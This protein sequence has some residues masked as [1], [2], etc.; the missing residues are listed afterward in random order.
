MPLIVAEA[1][2]PVPDPVITSLRTGE[3]AP[4][5]Q[6]ARG[7]ARRLAPDEATEA[8]PKW[9]RPEQA[10]SFQRTLHAVRRYGGA[11]LADPVGS[12]KTYVA[13]AVAA[14]L[15]PNRPIACLVPATLAGQWRSVATACGIHAVVSSHQA[16]SRGRLPAPT[17]GPVLIDEAHHFRNPSTRRYRHVAPWLIGRPVLL[18]TATPVVNRVED[19]LHQLLLGI[20][21]DALSLEGISSL[22]GLL[23]KGHGSPG[24]GSVVIEGAGADGSRPSRRGTVSESSRIEC[25]AADRALEAID[26][27]GLSSHSA[28]ARLVRSVLR[29]AAASSPAALTAALRRYRGLLLHARDAAAAGR[30][31]DRAAIRRFAGPVEDQLVWWELMPS[32]EDHGDLRLDDLHDIGEVLQTITA[33][34]A[35]PDG[36]L[37]RVRRLLDDGR[38]TLVFSSHRETVRYLR[39]RLGPPPVA[40]CTGTR[41]GLG[42]CPMPRS[43][44]LGWFRE[45]PGFGAR[46]SVR[47]LLVTDVAAEG[48]D[49]QRAGRVVH[50]DLPWTPMRI[51]Q[52]EG[53]A[54]RLGSRHREVEVVTFKPP[55]AVE[56]ALR[57]GQALELK[58]RLPA[59]AG[60]G[61]RGRGLWRWRSELAAAY[62]HGP[63]STGLAIVPRGP[64]GFLA[65]FELYAVEPGRECRL[66][67]VLVWLDPDGQWTEA[68]EIVAARLAQAMESAPRPPEPARLI[69]G[70]ARVAAPIRARLAMARGS[71]WIVPSPDATAYAVS[72]RLQACIRDAARRRDLGA[73]AGLERALA[74]VG[75]GHTAGEAM[76]LARLDDMPDTEF[77]RSVPH[78][79]SGARRWEAIEPR[80]GGVLLFVPE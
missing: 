62:G 24:L 58:A 13:L 18:V 53:R 5:P 76:A 37:E 44:V 55:S 80:L 72:V 66:A 33:L 67:S 50:Y 16:A 49:L 19:L 64:P 43:T 70:L 2:E 11:L 4:A 25:A 3:W 10:R 23:G 74:F 60:L 71:R 17:R 30:P 15:D 26:R 57:M 46:P 54:V 14:A 40:W 8:P 34:Q 63:A 9:L 52:R 47:H 68:E 27:L 41:A 21:D 7:M 1:L 45:G 39:D 61:S 56:R 29:R 73:L 32:D 78:L 22:R 65:G 12:G 36:K 31:L 20:R 6:V 48:L 79:P 75:G 28:T 35:E 69:D 51:E 77:L 42:A 59:M 38:T